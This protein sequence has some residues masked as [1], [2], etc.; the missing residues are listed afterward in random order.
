[1]LLK[2]LGE[3]SFI[4]SIKRDT[5]NDKETVKVGIGDD[6]AIYTTASDMDQI[7]T[8]DT[9]VEGVHF[10]LDHM[11]PFDIG[12]RL[13]TAN[14]SDIA[15]MGGY[16]KQALISIAAPKDYE[17]KNL[18]CIYDGIKKQFQN[19]K[20]NLIG[21]DT[22]STSGP[23]VLTMVLL[24]GVPRDKG[25]LRSTAKVGD[26]IGVTNSLGSA[27]VGLDVINAGEKEFFASK[28]A[29]KRPIPQIELGQFLRNRGVTAMTD[30][31]DGL[32]SE[33]HEIAKTSKVHMKIYS[34]AIPL[35][36]ETKKWA[37]ITNINPVDFALYGGED[38]QLVFTV[39]EKNKQLIEKHPFVTIIGEVVE[40]DQGVTLVVDDGSEV[41]VDAHGYDHFI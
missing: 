3:F 24:G 19:F 34:K 11:N 40:G 13:A 17:V 7:V 21:G 36:L 35:E 25:V 20:V 38:F 39:D 2:E 23:L 28:D 32:A 27:A 31:S 15:A 14:L 33:L 10:T 12:F 8:T 9:M 37:E 41:P 18:Q 1:M 22:V 29:F 6:C 4:D 5:I 16:P 30:V 26:Y